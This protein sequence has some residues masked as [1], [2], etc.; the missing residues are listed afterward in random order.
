MIGQNT[1]KQII[2]MMV[3]MFLGTIAFG[4]YTWFDNGRRA[5]AR[6]TMQILDAERG[7]HIFARNCRVCHGNNGLGSTSNPALI[8]P[9]LNTPA[10][11]LAWRTTNVGA[12]DAIKNR[13]HFTIA[14]GRNGTPMPSWAISEGGSMDAFKIDMLVALLTTNAGDAW[15]TV[16][17]LAREEDETALSNLEIALADAERGGD[18]TAI[19]EARAKLEK[20]QQRVD[21]GLP[22]QEPAPALTQN[23]CGQRTG[24]AATTAAAQPPAPDIDTS[25]FTGDAARGAELFINNGCIVCHGDQGQGLIG[26]T[27]AQ[28]R[29]TIEQV[30]SQ[31]RKPRLLMP[32]FPEALVPDAD[33]A[34]IYAWLH[35]LPIPATI[36]P[37]EGS[38]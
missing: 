7:A 24:G 6:S 20:A 33:V 32:P 8:G 25:G 1:Q 19:A 11:T 14:C 31:Y 28:T 23:T 16:L 5:E 10:N 30:L 26:P 15:E 36:V 4:A 22:I 2:A 17:E 29:F 18:A 35:T 12:F 9:A 21:A 34:D 38:P 37:G 13:F 27:I 3:L